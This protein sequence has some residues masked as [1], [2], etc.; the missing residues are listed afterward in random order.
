MWQPP[1]ST[2]TAG[3][4]SWEAATF[5]G[6]GLGSLE[7][8][9]HTLREVEVCPRQRQALRKESKAQ[10]S[11]MTSCVQRPNLRQNRRLSEKLCALE[12]LTMNLLRFF[13]SRKFFIY[14]KLFQFT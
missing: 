4:D 12:S 5:P 7:K 13:F 3:K 1:L 10:K 9:G 2:Q 11:P 8:E 6:T 14:K